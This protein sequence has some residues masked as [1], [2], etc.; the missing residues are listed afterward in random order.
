ME[1]T[2]LRPHSPT[3]AVYMDIRL[4]R[5]LDSWPWPRR[6]NPHYDSAKKEATVWCESFQAFSSQAQNVINK[7]DPSLLACLAYLDLDQAGCRVVCE[8]MIL[9]LCIDEYTDLATTDVA[10][11]QTSIVMDALRHP[12]KPRP[13]GEWVIGEMARQF[14]ANAV[15]IATPTAQTRFI[16]SFQEYLDAVVQQA[17][18]RAKRHVRNVEEYFQIRRETVG[19][20]PSFAIGQLYLNIPQEIIDHPV[21]SKLTEISI[22]LIILA[23]D[24]YS[25]KVEWERGDD[26]HNVVT[27]VIQQFRMNIQDAMDYIENLINRLVDQ[28]LEQWSHIPVFSGPV[29]AEIRAYCNM[30]GIWVRGNDSWS[31]ESERYFGERGPEVQTSRTIRLTGAKREENGD[32]LE[33]GQDEDL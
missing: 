27:V 12:D 6:I 9:F 32:Q 25:Y 22:D 31:F 15:L 5:T 1:A 13:S 28:F 2:T 8:L 7:V 19:A 21:I 4:P 26:G 11:S 30:L 29:D 20:K 16:S 10:R 14:W 23:N 17:E 18:D 33:G 3:D 24:V